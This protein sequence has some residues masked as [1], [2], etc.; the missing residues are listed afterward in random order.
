MK[1]IVVILSVVLVI[2]VISTMLGNLANNA[3]SIAQAQAQIET[4]RAAQQSAQATQIAVSG[5]ALVAVGLVSILVGAM[6]VSAFMFWRS[7]I[8]R[9]PQNNAFPYVRSSEQFHPAGQQSQL[10]S[11]DQTQRQ[12]EMLIQMRML[13]MLNQQ[14]RLP[15]SYDEVQK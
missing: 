15:A 1:N 2:V 3:A 5:L 6:L 14:Q 8:Q 13:E 12:I 10:T 4:A 11:G 9:R 7:T